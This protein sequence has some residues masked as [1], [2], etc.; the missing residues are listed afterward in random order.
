VGAGPK[1]SRTWSSFL[2]TRGT[3]GFETFSQFG[4]KI[5][6]PFFFVVETDVMTVSGM[7]PEAAPSRRVLNAEVVLFGGS[8]GKHH[9]ASVELDSD[10]VSSVP[11]SFRP[12]HKL[13]IVF[14]LVGIGTLPP[15][16]PVSVSAPPLIPRGGGLH[17]S[18]GEG[19]GESQFGRLEKKSSRYSVYSA[20]LCTRCEN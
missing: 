15:P 4:E 20:G 7:D 9:V 16:S 3:H 18:A 14:P 13:H 5:E 11:Y 19:V 1:A 2:W 8:L 12:V 10:Q 17:S 6:V